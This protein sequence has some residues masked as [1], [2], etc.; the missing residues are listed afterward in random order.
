MSLKRLFWFT[1]VSLMSLCL[2]LTAGLVAT[3]W[4]TYRRGVENVQIVHHLQLALRVMQRI[5]AER[6][7]SNGLLGA[8]EAESPAIRAEL[9]QARTDSDRSIDDLLDALD[10]S[11]R[12][13][14]R[15]IA[16]G[17]TALRAELAQAR[18][19][20]DRLAGQES[21][22][23]RS[24]DIGAAV[25]NMIALTRRSVLAAI[26][27]MSD[28]LLR[29]G[30][31]NAR[32][33]AS[34]HE[35]AEQ[36]GSQFTA[37]VATGRPLRPDEVITI[38]KLNGRA[39]Q[40]RFI[41]ELQLRSQKNNRQLEAALNKVD[42][43][44]FGNGLPMLNGLLA[45]G[46]QSGEYGMSTG[47]LAALYVPK[48]KSIVELGDLILNDAVNGIEAKTHRA[49]TVLSVAIGLA[50]LVLAIFYWLLRNI[51]NRLVTPVLESAGLFVALANGELDTP[52]PKRRGIQ[53]I[54]NLF[55]AMEA[56][57]ASCIA[58]ID[59]EREREALITQL[60][61]SSDTDFLTGLLNR[62]AFYTYGEPLFA[63][64][65]RYRND[66]AL[67]LMDIDYFKQVNDRHGHQIGDIV[68]Q[69][70]ASL[71]QR[72]HRKVDLVARYGGEEF[73]MLLPHTSLEQATAAAEKLRAAI[74]AHSLTLPSG[75]T[76]NIRASF[77]VAAYRDDATL[78]T[79][80]W[81]ADQALY[82]AKDGGR[83]QV[84]H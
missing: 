74:A 28:P 76:L 84:Q 34:L 38:A 10:S 9:V 11:Q 8:N 35:Y 16:A 57:K 65:Q 60:Q 31:A 26:L 64:A 29:N 77:G 32:L 49:K 20:V 1:A 19:S 83:N 62:R 36:I 23:R 2:L 53:E 22:Q 27:A 56:F 12:D 24:S 42:I 51:R 63:I 30:V 43:D 17:I 46:L 69:Q 50:G 25:N 21:A 52:I 5:S 73:L 3:Q 41:L 66:L 37:A 47:Q 58:R 59:L 15:P 75:A 45:T 71:C 33:A 7:P 18:Q 81:R 78:D 80:I 4:N 61:A 82:S 40:L 55:R 54:G 44:Y 68:L 14:Y 70:V 79:L 72:M 6:A 48:M 67:I 13:A 39:E